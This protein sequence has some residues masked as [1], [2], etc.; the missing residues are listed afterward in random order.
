MA[1]T[2]P[3]DFVWSRTTTR[4][5]HLSSRRPGV[6]SSCQL[7]VASPL[8]VPSLRRPLV[9][10]SRQLVVA[11]PLTVLSSRCPLV[12]LSH[13]LVVALPLAVL[14]MHHPLVYS[15]A[16][17]YIASPRTL[18]APRS[19]LSFSCHVGWLLCRLSMCRPLVVPPLVVS[20]CQLVVAPSSLVILLCHRP[21]ILSSCCWLV[22]ALPVF[23][24]P[25]RPLV[26][27]HHPCH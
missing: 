1:V 12:V 24:P 11:L 10:L 18:L 8:V 26:V 5:C 27:V 15:S 13:Q 19:A 7:V 20:L 23:A 9:V 21:L 22:V 3:I 6:V 16:C 25:S 17:Y 14:S 2:L 4:L